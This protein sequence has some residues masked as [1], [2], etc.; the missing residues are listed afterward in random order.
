MKTV[1]V[2]VAPVLLVCLLASP[3]EAQR[4]RPAE[5]PAPLAELTLEPMPGAPSPYH[6]VVTVRAL[7]PI[8]VA[9]DRRLVR[10]EIQPDPD[11]AATG[12]R[13]RRAPRPV[14]CEHPDRVARVSA[15]RIRTLQ[16]GE[17]WS[18]W[19]D[20]REHCWGR[21]LEALRAGGTLTT[22]LAHRARGR[23]RFA[24]RAATASDERRELVSA[25]QRSEPIAAPVEPDPESAARVILSPTDARTGRAFTLRVAVLGRTGTR[26]AYVRPDRVRFTGVGPEG[27]FECGIT[28]GGGVAQ[29]D[30]YQRLTARSGARFSLDGALYCRD[31]I[32]GAGVYEITPIVSLEQSGE[33]F[34][35]DAITGEFT[36]AP[37]LL[38]VRRGLRGGYVE[39]AV[40]AAAGTTP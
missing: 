19:I 40:G 24:V 17:T 37:S 23:G 8:E 27:P 14:R 10:F 32:Q 22:T 21:A 20:L 13:A 39:H 29:P 3:A 33:Q 36:G 35:L 18:E 11:P 12:R 30:L 4:R 7:A 9:A 6:R 31:A 38:R 28:P 16:P 2:T 15:E 5:P 34:G 1:L 25:P 26:R